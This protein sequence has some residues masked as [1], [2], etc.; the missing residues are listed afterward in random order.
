[1]PENRMTLGWSEKGKVMAEKTANDVPVIGYRAL[2]V[3]H[4]CLVA[5]IALVAWIDYRLP[6]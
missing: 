3:L 1:M 4:L 5:F 6:V 2:I